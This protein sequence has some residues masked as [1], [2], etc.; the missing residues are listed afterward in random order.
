MHKGEDE[1]LNIKVK[2]KIS[3]L[4]IM[5]FGLIYCR[6]TPAGYVSKSIRK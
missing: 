5:L 1:G 4:A 3:A 2:A 6:I